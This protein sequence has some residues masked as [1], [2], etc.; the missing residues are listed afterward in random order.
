[1]VLAIGGNLVATGANGR[2][3]WIFMSRPTRRSPTSRPASLSSIVIR[4]R[5]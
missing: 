2:I 4:G 3:P 5:P 1:V